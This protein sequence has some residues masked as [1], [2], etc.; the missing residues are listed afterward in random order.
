M[1]IQLVA[2]VLCLSNPAAIL[3][4]PKPVERVDRRL[5]A[6]AAVRDLDRDGARDLCVRSTSDG[7]AEIAAFSAAHGQCLWR[8]NGPAGLREWTA[9]SLP[10]AIAPLGDHDGDGI[11]EI[12][13]LWR[14]A[15]ATGE[16]QRVVLGWHSG[17]DGQ[18]LRWVDFAPRPTL[19]A[20]LFA[21]GDMDGDWLPDLIA[22]APARDLCAGRITAISSASGA[23]L[24]STP[25]SARGDAQGTSI[26][27]PRDVDGDGTVDIAIVAANG[28]DV[29]SGRDG[30]V[31]RH[32]ANPAIDAAPAVIA[33]AV[34]APDGLG[35]DE[36]T[37]DDTTPIVERRWVASGSIA[38]IGDVD[39]DGAIDVLVPQRTSIGQVSSSAILSLETGRLLAR[40]DVPVWSLELGAAGFQT[41]G[42]V[43]GDHR[44][45]ILCADPGW[46]L[47]GADRSGG[48]DVG[49]VRIL[50]GSDGRELRVWHGGLT[51]AR[52]GTFAC[53]AGDVDRDGVGDVWMSG[54]DTSSR[55]HEV[56]G[57]ASGRTGEFLHWIDLGR[58]DA[59][60][61]P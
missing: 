35:P 28:V 27:S 2:L 5:V 8:S 47:P 13:A 41:I 4:A 42:D 56:L 34:L 33:R 15:E 21:T 49:A 58:L 3:A 1:T 25:T 9:E 12:A 57:L 60:G 22:L 51:L 7:R 54:M 31:V 32:V 50:A 29:I 24:W 14:D 55:P 11:G 26:V 10:G 17:A 44:I 59:T 53:A 39:G 37:P 46:N 48:V 52:V 16:T 30:K 61:Q 6:I 40:H 19:A 23:T 36:L 20:T 18:L 45:D 38:A 43:D